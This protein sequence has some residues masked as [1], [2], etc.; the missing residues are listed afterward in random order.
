MTGAPIDDVFARPSVDSVVTLT[1]SDDVVGAIGADHIIS[2][3]CVNAPTVRFDPNDVW[4]IGWFREVLC[5]I[6][7]DDNGHLTTEA[8]TVGRDSRWLCGRWGVCWR[9]WT[10]S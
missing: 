6:L 7:L 2:A 9:S 3:Q 4:S 5:R 1:T 8:L 10:G